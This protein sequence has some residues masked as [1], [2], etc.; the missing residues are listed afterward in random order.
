MCYWQLFVKHNV[1]LLLEMMTEMV[2]VMSASLRCV[3]QSASY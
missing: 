1:M 2:A 3:I